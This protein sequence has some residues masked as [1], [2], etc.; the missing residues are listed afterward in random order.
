M[1]PAV[2]SAAERGPGVYEAPLQFTMRGDWIVLVTGTV[3]GGA[4]VSHRI[5]F[6]GVE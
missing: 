6:R 1:P 2:A 3:P 5:D 4:A